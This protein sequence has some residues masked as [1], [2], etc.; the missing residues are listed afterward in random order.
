MFAIDDP[1]VAEAL[2][3]IRN[4]TGGPLNVRTL[5]GELAVSRR[6]FEKSPGARWAAPSWTKSTGPRIELARELLD[7]DLQVIQVA[8]QAGFSSPPT[9]R[10]GVSPANGRFAQPVSPQQPAPKAVVKQH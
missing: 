5:V 3:Y 7:T 10:H 8:R 4:H 1:L 2:L 6:A 9:V